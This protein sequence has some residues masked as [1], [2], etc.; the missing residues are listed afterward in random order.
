[1]ENAPEKPF[2]YGVGDA[3]EEPTM[4]QKSDAR[5]VVM[6]KRQLLKNI[7]GRQKTLTEKEYARDHFILT[8]ASYNSPLL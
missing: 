7:H 2:T 6:E 5:R 1:M 8:C 3:V 4:L